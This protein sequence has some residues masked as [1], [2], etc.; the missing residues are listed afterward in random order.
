MMRLSSKCKLKLP[1]QYNP[2]L[3]MTSVTEDCI[4][5][6]YCSVKKG[7]GIPASSDL[8]LCAWLRRRSQVVSFLTDS[9]INSALISCAESELANVYLC[10][11]K[12]IETNNVH[13]ICPDRDLPDR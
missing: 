10:L 9:Y 1:I 5:L 12:N 8:L 2:P 11:D 3:R 13:C 7:N 4:L 6:S